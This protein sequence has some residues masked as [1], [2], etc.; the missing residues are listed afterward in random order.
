LKVYDQRVDALENAATRAKMGEK[1]NRFVTAVAM[2]LRGAYAASSVAE[3]KPYVEGATKSLQQMNSVLVEWEPLVPREQQAD[4]DELKKGAKAYTE[5]RS[6]TAAIAASDGPDAAEAFGNTDDNRA[7]RKAF[8]KDIDD[9]VNQDDA[10]LQRISDEL[11]SF[12]TLI[13]AITVAVTSVGLVGGG[14]VAFYIATYQVSRPIQNV[15]ETMKALAGGNYREEVPYLNRSDEVGE[16]A[17]AVQVFKQN[18]LE[19]QRMNAQEAAMLHKSDSFQTGMAAVVSA[20]AAGDFS[21][22]I[23]KD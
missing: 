14:A 19:V 9:V 15:T 18:G 21:K 22:R 8:Q 12:Q 5:L 2:D 20:A 13:L 1:L 4:F 16:M 23:S 11:S 7:N 3:T 10:S 6:R 17:A